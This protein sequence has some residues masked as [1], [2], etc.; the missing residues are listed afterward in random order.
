MHRARNGP[1]CAEP[2][3][4]VSGQPR[5]AACLAAAALLLALAAC[6][7]RNEDTK[8]EGSA[9][10]GVA[11]AKPESVSPPGQ[12]TGAG[13]PGTAIV[14]VVA[15]PRPE[16]PLFAAVRKRDIRTAESLLDAGADANATNVT[17]RTA[18][19]SASFHDRG[20]VAELLISRG[21]NVDARDTDGLSPLHAAALADNRALAM[22][23]IDRGADINARTKLG[24]TPLH[25][26][27]AT[28]QNQ[29]LQLLIDRG[30]RVD[31]QD[32]DGGTP[33]FYASRNGH[34]ATVALLQAREGKK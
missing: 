7:N 32:S 11:T 12:D 5:R 28:G 34:A 10:Q 15:E 19:H 17:G 24:L 30:A 27:S 6:Q 13:A 25:L 1:A 29:M 23:L 31:A 33:L 18:L 21:A 20:A 9:R 22:L 4:A 26:A 14:P 2:S 3:G 8:A 16:P